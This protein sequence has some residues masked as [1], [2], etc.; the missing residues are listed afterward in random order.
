MVKNICKINI[1]GKRG[2]EFFTKIPVDD[3]SSGFTSSGFTSSGFTSSG[4]TSSCLISSGLI[5]S[6]LTSS[7]FITSVF[8]FSAFTSSGLTSSGFISNLLL[9]HFHFF[10][11]YPRLISSVF[12]FIFT[13]FTSPV[14]F[15]SVIVV[16]FTT[17]PVGFS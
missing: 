6:G 8:A 13:S 16:S 11:I 17:S 3:I 15:S 4:L 9:S 5:S 2:N 12:S 7:G 14:A 1:D 10:T